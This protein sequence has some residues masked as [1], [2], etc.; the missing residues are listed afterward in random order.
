MA[1]VPK[2]SFIIILALYLKAGLFIPSNKPEVLIYRSDLFQ[3]L[4]KLLV[5]ILALIF[6]SANF[7]T[8]FTGLN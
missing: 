3:E 2:V 7:L 5:F 4:E 8:L 6:R 1:L